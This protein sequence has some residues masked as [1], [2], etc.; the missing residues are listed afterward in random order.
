[1]MSKCV[2]LALLVAGVA[3]VDG[4]VYIGCYHDDNGATVNDLPFFSCT[5]GTMDDAGLNCESDS[6]SKCGPGGHWG[7]GCVMS[8]SQCSAQCTGWKFFGLQSGFECFCGDDYG[9]QG[10]KA[11]ES[12]CSVPC[13]GDSG[14]MCGR[15][16]RNSIYA[17]PSAAQNTTNN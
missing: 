17:Q 13:P 16:S 3:A 1:M 14:I 9:N 4:P 11:P 7:G 15:N 2:M 6:R 8:P 12:D 10:G 5:N